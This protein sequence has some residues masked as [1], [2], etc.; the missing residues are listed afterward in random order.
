M[1]GD[2]L[3]AFMHHRPAVVARV[4]AD[5]LLPLAQGYPAV[6][7]RT[8]P[9]IRARRPRCA[10][11]LLFLILRNVSQGWKM[12]SREWSEAKTQFAVIFGEWFNED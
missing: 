3:E 1:L 12:A 10:S 5:E 6:G 2:K 7:L 11:K 8:V 9:A 4:G